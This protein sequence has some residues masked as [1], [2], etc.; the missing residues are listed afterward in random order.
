MQYISGCGSVLDAFFDEHTM[1]LHIKENQPILRK[2]GVPWNRTPVL[3]TTIFSSK[4]LKTLI[5]NIFKEVETREDG[6][7]EI[8]R[9]LSK[10]FQIGVYRIV[11]VY[12]PLSDG[13]ELTVAK[14]VNKLTLEDYHLSPEVI[15][16]FD[17]KAK[18]ILVSGAPWSGKTTFAQALVGL[19]EK[20]NAIIKTIEAP[21]DLLVSDSVVQYSFTYGSHDEVRDILLLSRPDYTIYDEVRNTSDFELYKDLRLTGIGLV[22]VIHAT[23]ALDSVQ[24]FLG[25]I[26][27][28]IVPQVIDTVVFIDKG[29]VEEI[30]Q[31]KLTV[32]VPEG[33]FSDDLAR[34][35]ITV[36]SFLTKQ[37]TH[38][39]YSFWEQIVVVPLG[40]EV[41]GAK[42][43]QAAI[44]EYAQVAIEQKLEHILPCDFVTKVKW[45]NSITLYIPDQ[46]KARVIGKWWTS[47][48]KLE[49]QI[50]IKIQVKSF[51]ELT[52][53]DIETT[54]NSSKKHDHLEILF[55]EGMANKKAY[56]LCDN[57]LFTFGIWDDA[58]VIIT[59]KNL[60]K[61]LEKKW[62]VLVDYDKI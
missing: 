59:D 52:L 54:V 39:M 10:V 22:G 47:I 8:D 44:W 51:E 57:R 19:Y 56:L 3:D 48:D 24:R 1:S 46:F 37:V 36:T 62:F 61:L 32:K 15:D 16:L 42:K 4:E 49:K 41:M 18:W 12:P 14:P 30:L 9:A 53:L 38:E 26:E 45:P 13:L 7:L 25:T 43:Q 35:V 50:G 29:K 11:I 58:V 60:V 2:K 27:L 20:S 28:G 55:P 6:C 21:R 33:M 34:P 31:L 40:E 23:K 17:N 5:E